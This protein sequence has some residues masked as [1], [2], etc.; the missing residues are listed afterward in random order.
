MKQTCLAVFLVWLA[1]LGILNAQSP[2]N[3][4]N[5][6]TIDI[7]SFDPLSGQNTDPTEYLKNATAAYQ[8][9]DYEKAARNYLA[10]LQ[11][12]PTDPGSWYNLSCCY[13]LLG[14]PE[15]A[16]K[17]LQRAYKNGFRDLEHIAND[18]DFAKVRSSEAFEAAM[19][20]LKTWSRKREKYTG[21]LHYYPLQQ[22]QPYRIMLPE[23]FDKDKTYNLVIGLHGFGDKA[24]GF[25][26]LWRYMENEELIFVVP[27]APYA[28]PESEVPQFSWDPFVPRDSEISRTSYDYTAK[29][30]VGLANHLKKEYKIGQTWLLGF[31]QGAYL[32]YIIGLKNPKT[33]AGFLACGGGLV[34]EML[35]EKDYKAAKNLKIL[36]SHGSQDKIVDYKESVEAAKLLGDKGLNV[37]MHSFEGGHSVSKEAFPLMFELMKSTQPKKIQ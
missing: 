17:Y 26:P 12:K 21:K 5:P 14:K 1:V 22:Y 35:R 27:E 34:K 30:I 31:S 29:Y 23:G 28:F 37:Q 32:S 3:L 11:M 19:D 9:A 18:Q 13:G 16:A 24:T 6:D 10:Y 20:S 7:Y 4:Q 8:A 33:F 25:A 2:A 36:I 15:L